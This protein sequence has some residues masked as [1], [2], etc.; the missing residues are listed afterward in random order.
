M[1]SH[2]RAYVSFDHNGKTYKYYFTGVTSIE[3]RDRISSTAPG[4]SR[5]RSPCPSLRR[6]RSIP[7]AGRRICWRPWTPSSGDGISVR[8]SRPWEHIRICSSP[9]SPRPRTRRTS[10]AG[11]GPWSSW[12]ACPRIRKRRRKRRRKTIRP[13]K[14]IRAARAAGRSPAALSSSCYREQG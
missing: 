7:P 6:M 12:N 4:T 11:A 1:N 9:G 3:H 5:I 2:S 10:A 8:S 13:A 14:R